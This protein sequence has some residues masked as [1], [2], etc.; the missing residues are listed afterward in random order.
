MPAG[1]TEERR[2]LLGLADILFAYAY[3]HRTTQGEPTVESG[4][5][6]TVLSPLLSWLDVSPGRVPAVDVLSH[7]LLAHPVTMGQPGFHQESQTKTSC[8]RRKEDP[9]HL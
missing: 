6:I 4:W 3:D 8:S 1:G 9:I 2:A 7:L 5:T